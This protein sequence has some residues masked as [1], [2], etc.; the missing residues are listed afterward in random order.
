[1]DRIVS[2]VDRSRRFH[3]VRVKQF[4]MGSTTIV[5]GGSAMT[6]EYAMNELIDELLV[7]ET[8]AGG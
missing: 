6:K 8:V 5:K 3:P 4:L 7:D 1:V 2:L